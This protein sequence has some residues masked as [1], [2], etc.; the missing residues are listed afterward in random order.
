MIFHHSANTEVMQVKEQLRRFVYICVVEVSMSQPCNCGKSSRLPACVYVCLVCTYSV[1][2]LLR[3]NIS[4]NID[5]TQA[6][7]HT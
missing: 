2:T 3:S 7:G 5:T 1:Y 4:L 6:M